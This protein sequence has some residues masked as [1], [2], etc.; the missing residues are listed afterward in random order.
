MFSRR[1]FLLTASSLVTARASTQRLPLSDRGIFRSW[2]TWIAEALYQMPVERRPR[3]VADCSALLRFSYREALRPH[4]AGWAASLGLEWMPPLPELHQP[5]RESAVFRTGPGPLRQ[6]ADAEHLMRFNSRL[7][8]RDIQRAQPGDLLFYRQLVPVE[9]WHSII[10]L[11][12]SAFDSL[13]DPCVVYH[14]G[15][16]P[17]DSGEIRRP[18]LPQ[19]LAHPEPRWR[20]LAGNGNFLG[21]YRWNL[22]STSD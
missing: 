18:T 17:H 22:L 6:F 14:T 3:E 13:P 12:P 19:L 15:P 9:P 21:V 2:F 20:P 8:T 7:V 1:A 5:V 11:G 10:F 16:T 4:T